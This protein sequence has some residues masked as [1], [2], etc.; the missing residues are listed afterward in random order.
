MDRIRI[1]PL[2]I[3]LPCDEGALVFD[4]RTGAT[5][6]IGH[7]HSAILDLLSDSVSRLVGE[8]FAEYSAHDDINLPAFNVLLASLEDSGLIIRC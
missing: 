8:L 6:L 7:P 3:R 5:C 4:E 1:Q 2:Q